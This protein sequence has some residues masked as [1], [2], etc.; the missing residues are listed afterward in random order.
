MEMALM[1]QREVAE[2]VAASPGT[3]TYG[4]LS[5]LSQM[6]CQV[7]VA[8]VVPPGAFR[9]PPR[10]DSAVLHLRMRTEPPV[11][12]ADPQR[13]RTVVRAAFAQR[14]KNLVNALAPGLGLS[15]DRVRGALADAG[16]D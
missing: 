11:P 8:F 13:F 10:V 7:H 4:A 5:V 16:I 3:R 9:P 15:A 14:R 12:V 1:L 2:R 6:A